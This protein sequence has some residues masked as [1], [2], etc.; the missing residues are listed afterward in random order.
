M[1]LDKQNQVLWCVCGRACAWVCLCLWTPQ[2]SFL[3]LKSQLFLIVFCCWDYIW[4]C[5]FWQ[6]LQLNNLCIPLSP[7]YHISFHKENR[8]TGKLGDVVLLNNPGMLPYASKSYSKFL[9]KISVCQNQVWLHCRMTGMY[10][11]LC[12]YIMF[13]VVVLC[14]GCGNG[15]D[16]DIVITVNQRKFWQSAV[17]GTD[18]PSLESPGHRLAS[19]ESMGLCFKHL[20][21]PHHAHTKCILPPTV[22]PSL[23]ELYP[24]LT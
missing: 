24:T 10:T 20:S 9:N 21:H 1:F 3:L 16:P 5:L 22:V 4:S 11:C 19:F 15:S 12:I 18:R 23:M 17:S 13:Y 14:L 8:I 2:S 6:I 7:I